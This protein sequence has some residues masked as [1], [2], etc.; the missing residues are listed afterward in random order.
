MYEEHFE[1][2]LLK[3]TSILFAQWPNT[4][5]HWFTL[6][7]IEISLT[8]TVT[9]ILFTTLTKVNMIWKELYIGI[10]MSHQFWK[11]ACYFWR[12]GG[13]KIRL[14]LPQNASRNK[15]KRMQ[16]ILMLS[17]HRRISVQLL[18]GHFDAFSES[19]YRTKKSCLE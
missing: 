8:D 6:I 18:L 2:L 13:F 7:K 15:N 9:W 19:F 10:L 14:V 16:V 17:L 3:I 12:L 4:I 1:P 5:G 11:L